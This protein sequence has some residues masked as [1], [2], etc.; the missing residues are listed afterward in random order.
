MDIGG[1]LRAA[2][3]GR[4][5]SIEQI[6]RIT[7]ISPTLLR[8]IENNDFDRVP[9]GLFTRGYLRAYAREVGLDPEA[10][11]QRYRTEVECAVAEAPEA[12]DAVASHD[13]DTADLAPAGE[14]SPGQIIQICVI[15]IV[16]AAYF[17]W[18]RPSVRRSGYC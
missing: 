5:R 7:K 4:K 10:L 13:V 8:A 14:S 3:R 9:G 2:R 6:A 1:E 17:A 11:V 16:V 15:V 12:H 18:L